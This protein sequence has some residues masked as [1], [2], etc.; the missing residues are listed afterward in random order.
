MWHKI[1][2]KDSNTK[3]TVYQRLKK[4]YKNETKINI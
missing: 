3:T 1:K 2:I 4:L